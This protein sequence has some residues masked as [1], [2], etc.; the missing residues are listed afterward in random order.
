[1]SAFQPAVPARVGRPIL[2]A[3]ILLLAGLAW[4]SLSQGAGRSLLHSSH[5][6]VAGGPPG[7]RLIQFAGAW[8]VMTV[9]MMLPTTLPLLATFQALARDRR[10]R[11]LLLVLAVLGYLAAWTGLGVLLYLGAQGWGAMQA[12][13][14]WVR[15]HAALADPAL[16][17]VAGS[18]QFSSLKYR[19]LEKCRSPLGFVLERWQGP[20]P[21]RQAL[22]LG[23]DHG[24]YC[25]G[26]CWALM[27]LMFVA[28]VHRLGW[29]LLLGLVMAVEKNLPRGRALSAPLGLL[30]IAWGAGLLLLG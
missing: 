22:R 27:L 7:V 8:T 19:C 1:M 24:L 23:L 10:D 26:C 5:H 18:F 25:V 9:A 28:G 14:R 17:L 21:G 16:L 15:G 13:N 11:H 20:A 3:A 2:T 30:L 12:G 6:A 4:L 29:M